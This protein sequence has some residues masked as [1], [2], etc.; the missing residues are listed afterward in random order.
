MIKS[1]RL[2]VVTSACTSLFTRAA[3]GPWKCPGS[4]WRYLRMSQC[5]FFSLV[6]EQ[7]EQVCWE[8][9]GSGDYLQRGCS[10]CRTAQLRW[11]CLQQRLSHL[12]RWTAEVFGTASSGWKWKFNW[13]LLITKPRWNT[14]DSC[15]SLPLATYTRKYFFFFFPNPSCGLLRQIYTGCVIFFFSPL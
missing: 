10:C 7:R 2:S 8:V 15:T 5:D 6:P 9:W 14:E 3:C 12:A 13:N 11:R 1:R 4:G